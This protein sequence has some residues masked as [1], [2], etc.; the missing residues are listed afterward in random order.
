MKLGFRLICI[1]LGGLY[2]GFQVLC[3]R[4]GIVWVRLL[5]SCWSCIGSASFVG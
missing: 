5:C 2:G 4:S 3:G 1:V